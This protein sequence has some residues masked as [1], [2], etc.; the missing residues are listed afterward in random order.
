MDEEE[1]VEKTYRSVP[2]CVRAM[3]V[4]RGVTVNT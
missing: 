1:A 2:K 4:S 3:A